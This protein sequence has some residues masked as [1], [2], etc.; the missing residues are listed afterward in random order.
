[1]Y[2]ALIVDDHPVVRMAI[3]ILL[4]R[5]EINVIGKAANGADAVQMAKTLNPDLIILDI[6]IPVLN[7]LEVISRIRT[8]GSESKILVLTS[9][10]ATSIAARCR[11]AGA[12]GFV[13]KTEDMNE[14]LDAIRA[15]RAGYTYFPAEPPS[16]GL[17]KTV[18]VVDE[19][20]RLTSL[21]NREMMVLIYLAKG[22]SNLEI[23]EM[24]TLSN[25]TISTYKSRLLMKL[26][27]KTLVDLIG[28]AHRHKLV[29]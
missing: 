7:G 2:N 16:N 24:M 13:E 15:I 23:G 3:E 29:E 8:F 4:N 9:Q 26:G 20:E 1:M 27:M 22:F 14:L 18:S 6:A 28:L 25:K 21:S 11:L 12:S 19:A 5:N 10:A 17:M